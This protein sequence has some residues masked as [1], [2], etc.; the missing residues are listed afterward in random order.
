MKAGDERIDFADCVV[1]GERGA[2]G[3]GY[4]E[5]VHDRLRAVVASA[6]GDAL[7][8]EQGTDIVRVNAFHDVG[9]NAGFFLR[10]ADEAQARDRGERV[11][12]VG[13]QG[14]FVGRDAI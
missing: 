7:P 6:D 1:E 12:A 4:V 3:G 11:G 8:V 9:E 14:T 2:G 10:R 13:E 5:E